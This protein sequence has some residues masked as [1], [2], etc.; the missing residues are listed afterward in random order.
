MLIF[1]N[2]LAKFKFSGF[3]A[4]MKISP[5]QNY[6]YKSPT[7]NGFKTPHAPCM[8][9]MDFDRALAH[10]TPES[11]ARI[12]EALKNLK[13]KVVYLTNKTFKTTKELTDFTQSRGLTLPAADYL[14]GSGCDNVFSN[15]GNIYLGNFEYK[16]H[17]RQSTNYNSS[18]VNN[19]LK[20][21]VE[22][23]QYNLST[24]EI[25]KLKSQ[26]ILNELTTVDRNFWNA[27]FSVVDSLD[28]FKNVVMLSGEIN[29]KEFGAEIVEKLKTR[30]IRSNY[31]IS[32]F[33]EKDIANFDKTTAIKAKKITRNKKNGITTVIF[34]PVGKAESV[35]FIRN[36][37]G[38]A[39][40]ELFIATADGKDIGLSNMTKEGAMFTCLKN[41]QINLKNYC[42]NN[43]QQ[44]LYNA[45]QSNGDGIVEGMEHFV[46][47][48][49]VKI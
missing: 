9:V 18:W 43:P 41:A 38:V 36:A 13:A 49:N 1:V 42:T 23:G 47:H 26:G 5:N 12:A 8:V 22:L 48:F 17:V 7:F 34:S 31:K 45:S 35:R 44:N 40:E 29:P 19:I 21:L 33:S 10:S 25:S 14:I 27:K 28:E 3:H 32:Y 46:K 16:T 24:E 11:A 2:I 39:P 15:Y 6:S 37:S 20:F 30:G 4:G